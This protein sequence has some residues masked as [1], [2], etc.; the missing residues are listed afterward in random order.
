[1]VKKTIGAKEKTVSLGVKTGLTCVGEI[2]F[3]PD[4]IVVKVPKD[5]DPECAKA[6]AAYILGKRP[7]KFEID[8]SEEEGKKTK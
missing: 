6:T 5:A 2:C 8:T 4:G 1:M 3:T 7:I